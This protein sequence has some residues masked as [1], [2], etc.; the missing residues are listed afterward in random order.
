M[1]ID[2]NG[3]QMYLDQRGDGEPLVLLHGG[4]GVGVNWNLIFDAPVDGIPA[5]RARPARARTLDQS[6]PRIQRRQAAA[7]SSPCSTISASIARRRSA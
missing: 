6:V 2:V 4:G 7:T 1:L 3:F 5:R